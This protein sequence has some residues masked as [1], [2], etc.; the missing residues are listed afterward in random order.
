MECKGKRCGSRFDLGVSVF[1][2][3]RVIGN[4]SHAFDIE[5]ESGKHGMN[6][7]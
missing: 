7:L 2:V 5:G 1:E 6:Y 4:Q 3:S